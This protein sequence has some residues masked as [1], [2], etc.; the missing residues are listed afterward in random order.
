MSS[1]RPQ[2]PAEVVWWTDT[3]FCVRC[4]YCDELHR[5]G[6]EFS[7]GASRFVSRDYPRTSRVPHCAFATTRPPYECNFPAAYEI[8]KAKARFVNI[9]TL[10]DLQDDE[11]DESDDEASL[12]GLLSNLALSD[13]K[14]KVSFDDSTEE[15]TIKIE[16]Q[17]PFTQRRILSAILDC[18]TGHVRRVEHYLKTSPDKSIFLHGK[19]AQ[20]DTCLIMASRERTSAMLPT[21][22]ETALMEA[23]LWG[24]LETVEIL[25]SRGA[26]KSLR[27]RKKKRAVDLALPDRR[28]WDV[29]NRDADRREIARI[30]E[31]NQSRSGADSHQQA[32]E[33]DG[34]FFRRSPDDLSIAYYA[35]PSPPFPPITSM[36]GWAHDQGRYLADRVMKLSDLVGHT[37]PVHDYDQGQPGRFYASHAEKQ[38][39]AYFIDRHVFLP[40]DK[41]PSQQFDEKIGHLELE[42]HDMCDRHPE[43]EQLDRELLDKDD[44]MLG[45]EYDEELVKQLKAKREACK[46]DKKVHERLNRISERAPTNTLERATIVITAPQHEVCDDCWEFNCRVNEHTMYS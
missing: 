14:K 12:P 2:P 18:V 19:D 5:H 31:E 28:A 16:G 1:A 36:S 40:E 22:R 8:D 15:V 46:D 39:I 33:P 30:L 38:L 35:M 17:E 20:G 7:S 4:P 10:S 21:P 32:F 9:R 11:K 6:I 43:S 13:T 42:I 25:L 29:V 26:D 24:R 23:A 45:D 37:L 41:N 27:D 44:R 34:N 3:Q